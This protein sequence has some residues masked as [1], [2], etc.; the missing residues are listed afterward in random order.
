M[1]RFSNFFKESRNAHMWCAEMQ[2]RT[3]MYIKR[4]QNST[5]MTLYYIW[6]S[7][8]RKP[9]QCQ[10]CFGKKKIEIFFF[11][12]KLSVFIPYIIYT[13]VWY[14]TSYFFLFLER[15]VHAYIRNVHLLYFGYA[16][17]RCYV[18]WCWRC[19]LLDIPH[20]RWKS[21]IRAT[22]QNIL[23]IFFFATI[24]YSKKRLGDIYIVHWGSTYIYILI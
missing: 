18:L 12:R 13:A 4:T 10:L 1:S 5:C 9:W 24:F 20:H 19:F 14:K 8:M 23:I 3:L 6:S 2:F 17:S 11:F 7:H 22:C 16:Y 15:R 21:L